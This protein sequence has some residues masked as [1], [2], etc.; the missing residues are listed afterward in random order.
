[1]TA[2]QDRLILLWYLLGLGGW[3]VPIYQPDVYA[4]TLPLHLPPIATPH[5]QHVEYDERH[6]RLEVQCSWP[7]GRGRHAAITCLLKRVRADLAPAAGLDPD[8]FLAQLRH[9]LTVR[10]LGVIQPAHLTGHDLLLLLAKL[11][12]A[13]HPETIGEVFTRTDPVTATGSDDW[14]DDDHPAA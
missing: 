6:R 12:E 7:V 10:I 2:S 8:R 11:A 3:L 9:F 13:Q 14:T 5:L 4:R 1:M